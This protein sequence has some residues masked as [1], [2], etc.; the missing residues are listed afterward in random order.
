MNIFILKT[1]LF[2]EKDTLEQAITH[3]EPEHQVES[4]DTTQ[5]NLDE[6]DWD[7]VLNKLMAAD[8][9]ITV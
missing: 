6:N 7:T 3:F 8:R 4:Y 9:V 5:S 1:N 2:A